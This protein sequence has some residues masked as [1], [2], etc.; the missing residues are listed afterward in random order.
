MKTVW[1]GKKDNGP[2][3]DYESANVP[4]A[5]Y[6]IGDNAGSQE[7][8]KEA[9]TLHREALRRNPDNHLT[10]RLGLAWC[11][12]Q[13]GKIDEAISEYRTVIEMA[14][15][16]EREEK[17]AGRFGQRLFIAEEAIGY[18]LPLLDKEKDKDEIGKLKEYQK[19]LNSLPTRAM[20]PLII[21]LVPNLAV[22]NL[23]NKNH[24]VVFDLDGSGILKKWEWVNPDVGFL[25][26][27]RNKSG[28]ISSA[29]QLFGNVTFW[30][31]WENGYEAMKALDDNNDGNL[32]GNELDGL[33]IWRDVNQNGRSEREEVKPL[34]WWGISKL[35]C[36]YEKK[37]GSILF[38]PLGVTFLNDTV[39]PTYDVLLNRKEK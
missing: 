27:D 12:E 37:T 38:N 23:I 7:Y 32:E 39:R 1:K 15:P 6:K 10:I 20:T 5:P 25:V 17:P 9:I 16:R 24:F 33:A 26:F 2:W 13:G 28:D 35:S 31:F 4:Y 22:T 30:L 8:L 29:L 34:S 11:L 19:H 21:P 18:L 14:W 3:F 36:G